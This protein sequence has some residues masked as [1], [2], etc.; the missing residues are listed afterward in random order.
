VAS[1]SHT[2]G[3]NERQ[4]TLGPDGDPLAVLR[5]HRAFHRA[6]MPPNWR[7]VRGPGEHESMTTSRDG[8]WMAI[9]SRNRLR[10]LRLRDDE[11]IWQS[12]IRGH[13][14]FDFSPDSRLLAVLDADNLRCFETASGEVRWRL[15]RTDA[16]LRVGE[17]AFS[18]DGRWIAAAL[19][20][21]DVSLIKARTGGIAARL[22]NPSPA[23]VVATAFSPDGRYLAVTL[24]DQSAQL[25][26]LH[27]LHEELAKLGL[28]W[29]K[30]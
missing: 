18:D 1:H 15:P 25:W 23:S 24:A 30:K 21:R 16:Y 8:A 22:T 26:D 19:V 2:P 11:N 27:V 6:G 3:R 20:R 13:G 28:D 5:G 9:S 14:R 10:L 4:L 12:S 29:E 17:V 7:P